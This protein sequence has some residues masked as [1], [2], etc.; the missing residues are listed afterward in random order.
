MTARNTTKLKE[1]IFN[2][3]NNDATLL[4]LLGGPGRVRHANPQQLSEYPL[5]VYSIVDELGNAYET[6]QPDNIAQSRILVESFSSNVASSQSDDLDDRVYELLNGQRLS[7]SSIQAY[8]I[9]RVS[10]TPIF[11]S[12]IEVWRVA[13]AYDLYNAT[14]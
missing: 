5:V 8:S 6:D 4:A 12:E 10:R 7:N 11:E 9:Y 14:I 3:L 1:L 2:T 13:S